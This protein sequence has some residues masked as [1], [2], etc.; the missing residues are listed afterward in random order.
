MPVCMP[1]ASGFP[2][3]GR[4]RR[5]GRGARLSDPAPR[6]GA[7]SESRQLPLGAG[8]TRPQRRSVGPT[9]PWCCRHTSAACSHGSANANA[10]ATSAPTGRDVPYAT[11]SRTEPRS[12]GSVGAELH[13]GAVE[14]VVLLVDGGGRRVGRDRRRA[15]GGQLADELVHVGDRGG[16]C[17]A[18]SSSLARESA[19]SRLRIVS[20]PM[21]STGPNAA[22]SVRAPSR[23]SRGGS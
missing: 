8:R 13:G 4:G 9:G 5:K 11:P 1:F 21:R 14:R 10:N 6:C 22:S 3:L 18:Y 12:G 7:G 16:P 20:W 19:M 2:R 15:A 17:A 23:A